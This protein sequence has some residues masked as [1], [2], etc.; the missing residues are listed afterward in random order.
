MDQAKFVEDFFR[1]NLQAKKLWGGGQFSYGYC[2]FVFM[3]ITM[4]WFLFSF[5]QETNALF[6]IFV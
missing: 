4:A 1:N 5:L 6:T 2:L 3:N